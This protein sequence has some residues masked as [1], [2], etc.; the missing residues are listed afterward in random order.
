MIKKIF[1]EQNEKQTFEFFQVVS[2][3]CV[4]VQKN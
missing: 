3:A 1:K 4:D 2:V